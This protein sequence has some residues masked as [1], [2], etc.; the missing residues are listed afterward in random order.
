MRSI[1]NL[2]GQQSSHQ[3]EA[4]KIPTDRLL[5][6]MLVNTFRKQALLVLREWRRREILV[7]VVENHD[8]NFRLRL[9]GQA[10]RRLVS[11]KTKLGQLVGNY[12]SASD[13]KNLFT[14]CSAPAFIC[15][16]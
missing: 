9:F 10:I 15:S 7:N 14:R 1:N 3:L 13:V 2:A 6:H 11:V 16:S 8:F 12:E 5:P 4:D